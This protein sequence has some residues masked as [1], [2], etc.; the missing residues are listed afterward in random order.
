MMYVKHSKTVIMFEG[1]EVDHE[2]RENT[3]TMFE[4][5][6]NTDK[7]CNS[8]KM[9]FNTHKELLNA[10]ITLTNLSMIMKRSCI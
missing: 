2:L 8:L 10:V 6:D 1:Y 5:R 3:L 7:P 4:S 9:E